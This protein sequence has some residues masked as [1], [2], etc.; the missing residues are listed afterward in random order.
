VILV[1]HRRA[2]ERHDPVAQHLVHGSLVAVHRI[3]DPLEDR[4]EEPPR[5]L[6]V[7]VG[8]QLHRAFRS[9]NSTVTCFRSPSRALLDRRI[10]SARWGGVYA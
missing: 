9:A 8:E 4:V 7:T 6:G 10:F 5:V 1:R 2:E 3:H